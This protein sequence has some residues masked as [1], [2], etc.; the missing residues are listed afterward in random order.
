MATKEDIANMATKEDIANLATK[1]EVADI[2][3]IKVAVLE[4]K[5]KVEEIQEDQ[6]S[7]HEL[8]GEH[9]VAIRTLRRKPV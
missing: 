2:P 1:E 3:A 7:I 8:L 5:H 4:T 6:K 9:E